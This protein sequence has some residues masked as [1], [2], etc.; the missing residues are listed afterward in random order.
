MKIRP[1]MPAVALAAAM[2]TLV[3]CASDYA[4]LDDFHNTEIEKGSTVISNTPPKK[5]LFKKSSDVWTEEFQLTSKGLGKVHV[6]T[7]NVPV[8]FGKDGYK[9]AYYQVSVNAG[10]AKNLKWVVW[11]AQSE[12]QM[13][14]RL[15]STAL[16]FKKIMGPYS[17]GE[18][19]KVEFLEGS[20][21][22]AWGHP[23]APRHPLIVVY[24]PSEP[25]ASYSLDLHK[26]VLTN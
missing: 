1:V 2:M 13:H 20:Q 7:P 16:H 4:K 19:V 9:P 21:T 10:S 15:G 14:S 8:F 3:G 11:A 17:A 23:Y 5:S 6:R 22:T 18:I 26:A 25:G 24:S 12:A